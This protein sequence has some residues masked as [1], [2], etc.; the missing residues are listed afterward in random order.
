MSAGYGAGLLLALA[1]APKLPG[2]RCRGRSHLFDAGESDEDKAVVAE[3]YEA[4]L[5]LCLA[6]PSLEA[7]GE[8][9]V[10]L[11][12]S[13]RPKGVIAGRLNVPSAGGRPKAVDVA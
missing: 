13:Q 6:C 3:R 1:G 5:H 2:A 8:W 9:F 10:S 4:A 12:P 7:C 11:R